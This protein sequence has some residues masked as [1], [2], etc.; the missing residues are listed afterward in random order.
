MGMVNPNLDPMAVMSPEQVAE[1][2][3][4][5][6][7]VRVFWPDGSFEPPYESCFPGLAMSRSLGDS[8]LDDIGVLPVPEVTIR[9]LK[10]KD[11]FMVIASDGIWQ[12]ACRRVL[13]LRAAASRLAIRRL[14]PR[15]P[16]PRG[17]CPRTLRILCPQGWVLRANTSQGDVSRMRAVMSNEEVSQTVAKAGGDATK[18]C[19]DLFASKCSLPPSST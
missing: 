6:G 1:L 13:P 10:P 17:N 5:L 8:C 19:Q 15:R 9:A 18:A 16:L 2:E 14:S 7:P 3:E 11:R 12:G 4:D